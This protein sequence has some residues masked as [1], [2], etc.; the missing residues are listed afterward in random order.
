MPKASVNGLS[1]DYIVEGQGEPLFLI[2]GFAGPKILWLSQ[3]RA[4]RKHYQVVIYDNR[5]A[6]R[7]SKPPGPYT[8]QMMADDAVGLM[9][10]LGIERAH[11]LGA[12]MGGMIAQH[13]ALS[14]PDRV[15]K[16]ILACTFAR[17]DADGG[18]TS[19]WMK[20]VGLRDDATNDELRAID[21]RRIGPAYSL[22]FN[23]RLAGMV[24]GPLM[25]LLGGLLATEGARAQF[26]AML[27]HDTLDQ[28]HTI[29]TPTLVIVGDADR[30]HRCNA[31]DAIASRMPNARLVKVEGGSHIFFIGKRDRFNREVLGFLLGS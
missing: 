26:E 28:L 17:R 11:V 27:D 21:L 13:I 22:A 23:G 12:S 18:R 7:S 10:H 3:R 6:G 29:Q 24:A 9:D 20:R 15:R 4:F 19:E 14:Y 30:L 1:I 25:R 31:S 2:M 16:L 5:G 8:M